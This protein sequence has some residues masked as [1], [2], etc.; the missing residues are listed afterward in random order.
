MP[1]PVSEET[2]RN[3]WLAIVV[4]R[5]AGVA[6]VILG[7]LIVEQAIDAPEVLGYALALAGL[8][9]TFVAPIALARRWKTPVE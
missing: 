6:M 4:A 7:L 1:E 9:G 8:A 5:L 3:R 2:A